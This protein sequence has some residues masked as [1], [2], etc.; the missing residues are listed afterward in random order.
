MWLFEASLYPPELSDLGKGS[1]VTSVCVEQDLFTSCSEP[2][3]TR[4]RRRS[5]I[6]VDVVP[7]WSVHGISGTSSLTVKLNRWPVGLRRYGS[8]LLIHMDENPFSLQ[9]LPIEMIGGES[10]VIRKCRSTSNVGI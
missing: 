8:W 6:V 1:I 4:C 2:V 9:S 7:G 5:S 10:L 3:G